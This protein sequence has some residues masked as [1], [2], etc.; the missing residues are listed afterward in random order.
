MLPRLLEV[1]VV[2]LLLV[3]LDLD[4]IYVPKSGISFLF[5]NCPIAIVSEYRLIDIGSIFE[6]G[7]IL[8]FTLAAI[9]R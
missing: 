8:V 5:P 9:F 7:S 3:I 6:L 1:V 2:V 4:E